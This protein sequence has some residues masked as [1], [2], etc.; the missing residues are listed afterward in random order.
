MS[1]LTIYITFCNIIKVQSQYIFNTRLSFKCIGLLHL[2]GYNCPCLYTEI[3]PGKKVNLT[4]M[5]IVLN[6]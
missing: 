3:R 1:Y 5:G 6:S 4:V 2:Y